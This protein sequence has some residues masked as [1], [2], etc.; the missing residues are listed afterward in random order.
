MM[1]INGK[2][3]LNHFYQNCK[4]Y[5]D[6]IEVSHCNSE[7]SKSRREGFTLPFYKMSLGTAKMGKLNKKTAHEYHARL[8]GGRERI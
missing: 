3:D 5:S 6:C 8:L 7:D 2:Y 4:V 1:A